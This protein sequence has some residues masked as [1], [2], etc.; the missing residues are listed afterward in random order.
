MRCCAGQAR[1]CVAGNVLVTCCCCSCKRRET[2]VACHSQT[3]RLSADGTR[4]FGIAPPA[5]HRRASILY[6]SGTSPACAA[7]RHAHGSDGEGLRART[8]GDD[9]SFSPS[10]ASCVHGG[11]VRALKTQE[12][13]MMATFSPLHN[14]GRRTAGK[15]SPAWST[16]DHSNQP[17]PGCPA[18]PPRTP[19]SSFSSRCARLHLLPLCAHIELP[20]F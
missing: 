12:N 4:H 15:E 8:N 18:A 10:V 3:T 17:P 9:F 5:T 16:A 2:R 6:S 1:V 13:A 14:D 19:A 20:P 7:M 11:R